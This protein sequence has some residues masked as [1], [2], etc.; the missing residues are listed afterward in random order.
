MPYIEVL[1][2]AGRPVSSG[3]RKENQSSGRQTRGVFSEIKS[4]EEKGFKGGQ[5]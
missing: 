2:G 3:N 1:R 4:S 5:C